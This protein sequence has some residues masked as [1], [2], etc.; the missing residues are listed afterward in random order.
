MKYKSC[1]SQRLLEYSMYLQERKGKVHLA[2][3]NQLAVELNLG[4]G[5]VKKRYKTVSLEFFSV[6]SSLSDRPPVAHPVFGF[7]PVVLDLLKKVNKT[8]KTSMILSSKVYY[9]SGA[10]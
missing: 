10:M 6:G 1:H 5:I 7:F 3:F 2:L 8:I 4:K 9:P